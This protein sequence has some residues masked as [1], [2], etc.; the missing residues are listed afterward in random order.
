MG[1]SSVNH[2]DKIDRLNIANIRVNDEGEVVDVKQRK[3]RRIQMSM[4]ML[5]YSYI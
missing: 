2:Y 3:M 5:L 1:Y 4:S